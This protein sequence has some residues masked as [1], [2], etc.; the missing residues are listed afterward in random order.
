MLLRPLNPPLQDWTG[1]SAWIIGA[2]SGIGSA[3]AHSLHQRGA[4]VA[5]SA[6][7]AAGLAAFAE[8]HPQTC[9]LPLD[10]TAPEQVRLCAEALLRERGCPDLVLYCAGTYRAMTAKHFDA[11]LAAHH[12]AVNYHGALHVLGAVLPPMLERG[13]GHLSL[14][15][16]V[17]GYR[18]LP[19]A[20]AYGPTKAAL[21][22]LGESLYLDLHARGL[23]V[24]VINPGFVATPMT[25]DNAFR[26]PDLIS[27]EQAAREILAGWARGAFEIHFPRRFTLRL[28]LLDLL[29]ARLHFA[30]VRAL[31]GR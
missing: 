7:N 29:P 31:V 12:M 17:A 4:R 27:P 13:G 18:A 25:A 10:V 26:M 15:G 30:A 3:V 24:S 1:R 14:V 28:K 22:Y 5:V 8:E 9:V 19:L 2:S 21:H 20:L 6:R 23:G 16:S 11:A